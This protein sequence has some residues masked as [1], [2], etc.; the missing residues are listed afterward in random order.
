MQSD[1]NGCWLRDQGHQRQKPLS[2]WKPWT[3]WQED[4]G[5]QQGKGWQQDKD[6][7]QD[8]R[9]GRW[10]KNKSSRTTTGTSGRW[11]AQRAKLTPCPP[12]HPPPPPSKRR[13]SDES[14]DNP[15]R[16]K[17]TPK[18]KGSAAV[19]D[20]TSPKVT[21]RSNKALGMTAKAKPKAKAMPAASS[22][23]P[24]T[25]F[26]D[27]A[28]WRLLEPI[29]TDDSSS[30]TPELT[31]SETVAVVQEL[32]EN[33]SQHCDVVMASMTDDWENQGGAKQPRSRGTKHSGSKKVQY[34]RLM[35]LLKQIR[36]NADEAMNA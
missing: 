24:D 33:K 32:A 13:R 22:G 36:D 28:A 21:A 16:L 14:G 15:P 7:Q 35:S 12:D 29:N 31:A 17:P 6:W 2:R 9:V 18:A 19:V 27:E 23:S 8:T 25:S 26:V 3:D 20:L 5:W 1:D 10:P 34:A 30:S 11:H 4:K